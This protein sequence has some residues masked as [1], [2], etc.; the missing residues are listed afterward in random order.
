VPYVT[1]YRALFFKA[2]ARPAETVLIHGATG[3]VGIAAVQ[4]A[5]AAGMKVIGTGG[6]EAGLQLVRAQGADMAL[7]HREGNYLEHVMGATGG[8]RA[9]VILEVAAHL[10]LDKELSVLANGCRVVIVGN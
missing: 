6:T 9:D 4:L 3:G 2:A 1:A 10:N 7:N 5:H 8:R